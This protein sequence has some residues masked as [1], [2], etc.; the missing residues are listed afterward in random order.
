MTCFSLSPLKRTLRGTCGLRAEAAADLRICLE[1][2][3]C[4]LLA[5]IAQLGNVDLLDMT[6]T[7]LNCQSRYDC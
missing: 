1:A 5:S 7:V 3:H 2:C 4:Y 6:Y